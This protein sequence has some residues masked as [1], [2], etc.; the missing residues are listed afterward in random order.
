MS[1][2]WHGAAW[3]FV[4]WGFL[5]GFFIAAGEF[6]R[7]WRL[8]LCDRLHINRDSFGNKLLQRFVVFLL[9]ATSLTPFFMGGLRKTFVYFRQMLTVWNPWTLFDG[10][11]CTLGMTSADWIICIFSGLLLLVVS[12]LREH[13]YGPQVIVRQNA[14]CKAAV[15]MLMVFAIAVFGVYGAQYSATAFMYAGF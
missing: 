6:T 15:L 13:G 3:T 9:M 14:L 1:G 7:P 4:L 5:N 11:L 12:A 8:K 2:L 10:T